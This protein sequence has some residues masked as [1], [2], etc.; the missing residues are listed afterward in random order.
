MCQLDGWQQWGAALCR[1]DD[2]GDTQSLSGCF[3]VQRGQD[4]SAKY[5]VSMNR[6]RLQPEDNFLSPNVLI[7]IAYF[8]A[9]NVPECVLT[10]HSTA[11]VNAAVPCPSLLQEG[12]LISFGFWNSSLAALLPRLLGM[13]FLW[14]Y[15]HGETMVVTAQVQLESVLHCVIA[16]QRCGVFGLIGVAQTNLVCQTNVTVLEPI[17]NQPCIAGES[18]EGG[19]KHRE[20]SLQKKPAEQIPRLPNSHNRKTSFPHGICTSSWENSSRAKFLH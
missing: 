10:L 1:S 14:T 7:S 4:I 6:I 5:R 13:S 18:G 9:Y 16:Q 2:R 12:A 20:G 8:I 11:Q 17:W 15:F 19:R 3:V